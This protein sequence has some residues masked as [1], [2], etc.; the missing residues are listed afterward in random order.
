[1]KISGKTVLLF[2]PWIYDFAAYDFWAKPIG[3]LYLGAVLRSVGYSVHLVDCLDRFHPALTGE[4]SPR[5]SRADATGKF[6]RQEIEKPAALK[7]VPRRYCRY[8]MPPDLVSSLLQALPKPDVILV[9]SMMTYWYPAVRDAVQMLRTHFPNSPILLGGIY[10]TLCTEH[11]HA[12]VRPDELIA[13]EGEVAIVHRVAELTG[14]PGKDFQY[15]TLDDLP[16]PAFDL[17]PVLN[18]VPLLTSRGCP[19]SCSFCASKSLAGAYRRRSPENVIAEI[20]HWQNAARVSNFAFFDDALLHRSDSFI[21]PVLEGVIDRGLHLRFHTPNGLTPRYMDAEL[22]QLFFSSGVETVRLSFETSNPE[23]QRS[24]SAKVTNDDLRRA[25]Q[26]LDDAGYSRCDL[27]VYVLMGLPGQTAAEFR[28]SALMVHDLGVR[29]FPASFSPIPTTD[30]WRRAID[31]GQWRESD[32]LLLTN[33]TLFPI[34]SQSMGYQFCFELLQWAKELNV[35]V[36]KTSAHQQS[37]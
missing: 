19:N 13:G 15:Q 21:K 37:G 17:Y 6:I 18:S 31:L 27:G 7:H 9:T 3:L 12:V 35:K 16:F 23:R 22:A 28:E 33:T 20:E 34:W 24:M 36:V 29:V 4:N 11:A 30:E 2:N 5:I 32:D 25:L 8:G 14:G 10:A 1:M 26:H